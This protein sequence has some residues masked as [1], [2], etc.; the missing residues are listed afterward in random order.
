MEFLFNLWKRIRD[1]D[2]RNMTTTQWV[3]GLAGGIIVL[4]IVAQILTFVVGILNFVAPI[5]LLT[6]IGYFGYQ[7]LQSREED[8]PAEAKKSDREK[9][10]EQAVANYRASLEDNL[11]E[12]TVSAPQTASVAD[13]SAETIIAEQEG[14]REVDL[15]IEQK[16]NPET[17]FKEPDIARL[18][19]HEE[20][21]LAEADQVTDDI[22]AQ[23][24]ARRR[25]LNQGGE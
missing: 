15:I 12:D 13:E 17:G 5:A 16:V 7:Y 4:W 20:Q 11:R 10:V 18:I 21:K 23:I 6:I 14:V 19:E 8:I 1:F 9:E 25:R 2:F 24:E 22:M 3:L